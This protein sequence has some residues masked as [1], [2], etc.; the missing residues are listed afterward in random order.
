MKQI[1]AV[2]GVA[3]LAFLA[4]GCDKETQHAQ[5]LQTNANDVVDNIQYVKDT[6]TGLCF[7]YYW[8]SG[9]ALATV[10]CEAIPSHLLTVAK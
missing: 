4:T 1:L 2:T 3:V 5:R 6:R 8:G 9:L 7:T 10:P